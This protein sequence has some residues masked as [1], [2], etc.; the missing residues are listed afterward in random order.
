MAYL[1]QKELNA[2]PFKTIGNGVKISSKASI[3]A[4]ENISIGN[5]VRIDDFAIISAAGGY[6]RMHN[7]IHIGP[8]SYLSGKGGIEIQDYSGTSSKVSLYSAN[9]DYSGDYLMGPTIDERCVN[10]I[11]EPIIL[12]KYS[13][14]GSGSVVL[15]GVVI[16]E[17]SILGAL[18][19]AT[20]STETWS[21]YLGV[22]AKKIKNRKKGLLKHVHIMEDKWLDK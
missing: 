3:Y 8:F 11:A 15:P 18:S 22:P 13:A 20:K 5:N 9:D 17:G 1:T 14:V 7:H 2:L 19:L 10:T 12:K 4:P 16:E 21:M 6:I